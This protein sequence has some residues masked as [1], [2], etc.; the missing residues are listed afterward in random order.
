MSE[1][2][3]PDGL[4]SPTERYIIQIMYNADYIWRCKYARK[5]ESH[6]RNDH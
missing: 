4:I 6:K 5:S 2:F 3:V 1:N